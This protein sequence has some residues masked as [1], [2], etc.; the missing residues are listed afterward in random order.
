MRD[1]EALFILKPKDDEGIEKAI[2]SVL[3]TIEKNKGKVNN[4]ENWGKQNIAFKI[5]KEKEGVYY[6]LHFSAEPSA[7]KDMEAA[8]RL[9]SDI[10]RS[11]FI[12]RE[13]K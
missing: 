10:L 8:Y 6:K 1:Y 5:K 3:S 2:A 12:A 11:M 7:I 4:Q 13:S 9:N